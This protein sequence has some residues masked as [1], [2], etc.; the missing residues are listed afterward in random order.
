MTNFLPKKKKKNLKTNF[1]F[2]GNS[3]EN[4]KNNEADLTKA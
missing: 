2:F 3:K 1:I 4:N